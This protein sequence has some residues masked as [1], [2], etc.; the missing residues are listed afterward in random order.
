M[1]AYFTEDVAKVDS[2]SKHI[3]KTYPLCEMLVEDGDKYPINMFWVKENSEQKKSK[4]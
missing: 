4:E 2:D 1:V 3:M